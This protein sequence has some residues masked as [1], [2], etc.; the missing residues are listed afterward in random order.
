MK[1]ST[2]LCFLVW[3]VLS[4]SRAQNQTA[5][6]LEGT[7]NSTGTSVTSLEGTKNSTDFL[8]P[9]PTTLLHLNAPTDGAVSATTANRTQE[10]TKN[11]VDFDVTQDV[12]PEATTG[13][14]VSIAT[15]SQSEPDI[16]ITDKAGSHFSGGYLILALIILVIA[17]LCGILWS[18][19]KASRTYSFDL[20]RLPPAGCLN[21]PTG[22]FEP[23]NLDD[24]DQLGSGDQVTLDDL[25][26]SLLTNGT[27]PQSKEKA[28]NGQ[29]NTACSAID[30]AEQEEPDANRED[31]PSTSGTSASAGGDP[32][33]ETSNSISVLMDSPAKEEQNEANNPFVCV[34]DPFIEIDLEDAT[35][36]EPS[37]TPPETPSSDLPSTS[38]LTSSVA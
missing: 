35:Q 3:A 10:T 33:D 2:H 21:E 36:G 17:V 15:P 25:S 11:K 26:P 32:V 9:T 4:A 14:L 18:L 16:I 1:L 30:A 13:S 38:A 12:G 27:T 22:T 29:T 6:S 5:T 24:L 37:T 23:V 7:K 20:Q 8:Q 28:P 19:R 34:G 31:V